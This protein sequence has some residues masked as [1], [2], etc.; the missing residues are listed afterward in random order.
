MIPILYDSNE[1]NFVSNGLGRLRDIASCRVTEGR[2]DVFECDFEYPVNGQNYD[3]IQL[4]RVISAQYDDSGDIQPFDIVSHSKPIGGV[5]RFHAVHISY[6]QSK[7]VVSGTGIN[8]LSAAL[9]MLANSEPDNPF[10][11]ETDKV[12]A[13]YLAAADGTPRSVKSVLGGMEGSIL[14]TY[15]GEYKFNKFLVSLMTSRGSDRGFTIRHGVNLLDYSDDTNYMESYNSCIPYWSGS[16]SSGNPLIVKGNRVDL[17][18]PSYSGRT[19]C[20]P[21]ELTGK[22]ETQPTAAQLEAAARTFMQSNQVN[23]PAQTIRVN[24]IRLQDSPEYAEYAALFNCRLCD[25]VRVV[26]PRYNVDGKF[27]IVKTVYDPLM[28]RYEEMELGAL[29]TTLSQAL[30]LSK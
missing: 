16:D 7:I 1:T 24:F 20:I 23:L 14:D 8:N 5:V 28:E 27:K 10:T 30:G 17:D 2:N 15:G 9:A 13:G 21:L 18:L 11:Y 22:F 12:S 25:T 6:R 4:G 19:E 26:F 29:S 3:R